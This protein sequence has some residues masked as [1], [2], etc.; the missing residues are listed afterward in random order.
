MQR[1][2]KLLYLLTLLFSNFLKHYLSKKII[3]HLFHFLLFEK[4]LLKY[5]KKKLFYAYKITF[6]LCSKEKK[7]LLK[8]FGFT[9]SKSILKFQQKMRKKKKSLFS[10]RRCLFID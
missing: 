9:H 1:K 8:K 5:N 10:V 4:F 2:K 6:Y 7:N 3:F